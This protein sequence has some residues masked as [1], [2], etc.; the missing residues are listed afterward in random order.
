VS[1]ATKL[2]Q[3]MYEA[4]R[5]PK[6]GTAPQVMGG[7]RFVQVGDAADYIRK[8][9]AEKVVSMLPTAIE[10][11]DQSEVATNKG[12]SMT[13]MTVRTTWT[14]TDGESGETATIQSL[15]TGGDSGDKYS[16][17]A[18]TSAMKYALLMG[19]LLSTGDDPEGAT[20]PDRAPRGS[21]KFEQSDDGG[22]IGIVEVGDKASSDFMLRQT[23]EGSALGFRLKA[24]G[25][26]LVECRGP[27]AD[28]L[29]GLREAVVGKRVTV[30]GSL[31]ERS[32]TPT[33]K[34]KVTYQVLSASRVRV[35]GLGD[36]PSDATPEPDAAPGASTEAETAELAGLVW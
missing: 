14:L 17:K 27:L 26:I 29:V 36:V 28:Q 10:I 13:V 22:L 11:V 25:G 12:G 30:W 20:L 6:N 1:L 3:V 35:P 5:I 19:F 7:Y 24:R 4:E 34:P 31:S 15:G 18:Q 16:M 2:A 21:E 33:G 8:A 9:L 32:F 23:P